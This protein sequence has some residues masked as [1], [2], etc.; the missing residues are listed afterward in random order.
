[1]GQLYPRLLAKMGDEIIRLLKPKV[2]DVVLDV[3]AGMHAEVL[4]IFFQPFNQFVSYSFCADGGV[5]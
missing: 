1:M 3:A 2:D 5:R 4:W